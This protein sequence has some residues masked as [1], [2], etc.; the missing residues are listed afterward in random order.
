MDSLVTAG[1]I[2]ELGGNEDVTDV[3]SS[4]EIGSVTRRRR[5]RKSAC[6][7]RPEARPESDT[8]QRRFA[9]RWVSSL[10]SRAHAAQRA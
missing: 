9:A 10:R 3:I 5:A 4:V 6:R 1:S 7:R 2:A 8:A